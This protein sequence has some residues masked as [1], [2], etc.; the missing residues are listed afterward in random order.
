M[1]VK[2]KYVANLFEILEKE[3]WWREMPSC[4]QIPLSE[5][6]TTLQLKQVRE[7]KKTKTLKTEPC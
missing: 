1:D 7:E 4:W 5:W 2:L 3:E 6:L